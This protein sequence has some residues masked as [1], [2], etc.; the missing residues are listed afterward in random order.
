M[1]NYLNDFLSGKKQKIVVRNVSSSLMTVEA[2]VPQGSV[3]GPLLFLVFINDIAE[4]LLSLTRF[5]L[6]M[7]AGCF[8][9]QLLLK[10]SKVLSITI[11]EC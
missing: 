4:S 6:Q 5:F 10:T 8:I 3:L 11:Y 7:T 9:L 1:V 2:G